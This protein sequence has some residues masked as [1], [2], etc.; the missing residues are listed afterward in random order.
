MTTFLLLVAFVIACYV[1][2]EINDGK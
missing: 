2:D 1:I